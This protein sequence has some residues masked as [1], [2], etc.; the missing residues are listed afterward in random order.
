MVLFSQTIH[1]R[2]QK[3]IVHQ[4]GGLL[5]RLEPL[6]LYCVSLQA[7]PA[8]CINEGLNSAQQARHH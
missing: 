8:I 6:I 2:T 1:K 3:L 4:S 7:C 5:D